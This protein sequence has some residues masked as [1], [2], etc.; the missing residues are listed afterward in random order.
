MSE[1]NNTEVKENVIY[2]YFANN[3]KLYTSNLSFAQNRAIHY[4]SN[5]VYVEKV[6]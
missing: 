3:I 4:G 1:E 6:D 5:D 2:Y